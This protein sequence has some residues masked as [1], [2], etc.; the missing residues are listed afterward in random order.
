[1]LSTFHDRVSREL[2]TSIALIFEL[3]ALSAVHT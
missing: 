2:A 1:M 3:L